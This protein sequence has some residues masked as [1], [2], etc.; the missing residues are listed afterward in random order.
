MVQFE[1][2][3]PCQSPT[4]LKFE[5]EYFRDCK[6]LVVRIKRQA[7]LSARF[8]SACVEMPNS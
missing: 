4:T 2:G 7:V 1:Q 6:L 3:R 8:V 5:V